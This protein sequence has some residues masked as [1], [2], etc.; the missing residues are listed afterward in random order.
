MRTCCFI[1]HRTINE[2]EELNSR[3]Y[4]AI[5]KLILE[6]RV[7]T[8]IFGSKSRFDSLCLEIVTALKEKYPHVKR[9]YVRAEFPYI[10]G[11]YQRYLEKSYEETY[12]PERLINA[13]RA[14]YVER[15]FEM[16]DKSDFCIFYYD[17]GYTPHKRRSGTRIAFDYAVKQSKNIIKFP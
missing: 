3:L 6:E 7:Y 4:G 10:D 9:I 8:F 12:Y 17:E 2:T 15:N 13:G 16:I 11:Q 5:E 1:G 14:V